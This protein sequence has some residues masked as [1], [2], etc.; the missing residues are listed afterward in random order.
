VLE[1]RQLYHI[2]TRVLTFFIQNQLKDMIDVTK[3]NNLIQLYITIGGE[4]GGGKFHM[5]ITVYLKRKLCHI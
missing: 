5:T 4:H 2:G 1:D 3:L